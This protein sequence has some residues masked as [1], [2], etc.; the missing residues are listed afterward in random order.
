MFFALLLSFAS[1]WWG[2]AH[3]IIGDIA[4]TILTQEQI[5]LIENSIGYGGLPKEKI[6]ASA[7]WQDEL[8]DTYRISSMGQWHFSDIPIIWDSFTGQIQP[9]TYNVSSYLHSA[10]K[11][12]MDPT[13]TD[14]WA[15][16]FHLRSMI[17]FIGD[18][19]T[20]HHNCQL[21]AKEFPKG[22]M[23]GNLY[24]LNCEYGSACNNIHFLWDSV[25]LRYNIMYPLLDINIENF[26]KNVTAIME[27]IPIDKYPT[28]YLSQFNPDKWSNESN[29][30][31]NELGYGTPMNER[32][33]E[34]FLTKARKVAS[35]RV[36]LAGYRLGYTLKQ[37]VEK[38]SIPKIE[39]KANKARAPIIWTIDVLLL[40]G[41]TIFIFITYFPKRREDTLI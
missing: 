40:V 13:T 18:I 15:I 34:E 33:S 38:G 31:A 6:R 3:S 17:H 26:D 28:E 36:I 11:S 25:I 21:Y 7:T 23:G 37:I 39:S 8:K 10:W 2:H 19:H 41:A 29:T 30:I 32:P 22:D 1:S 5:S 9:P 14:P 20:P 27:E 24:L 4:E 12:L 35:E 16:S